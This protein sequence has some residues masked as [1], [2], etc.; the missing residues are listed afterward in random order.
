MRRVPALDLAAQHREIGPALERA[1]VRVLRSGTFILGPE[2]AAFESALA[3]ACGCRYAYGV[4]SGTDALELALRACGIGPGDEVLVPGFTF[5]ATALAVTTVGARPVLVDVEPWAFGIDPALAE[6]RVTRR[7]RAVIAVHLY[8]QPCDMA[9]IRRL[10]RR[11]RLRVIEDCA[12]AIGARYAGRPVGSVGD[13]GCF[14]F[15]PTKNLGAAGD[16]GAAVTNDR[17][18]ARRLALARN[19]GTV[20]K[21]RY[22]GFG[23]NSRLDELQ[24]ALLRV[25]LRRLGAWTRAR[26]LRARWYRA[27]I[28]RAGLQNIRLPQE[29]GGR[30]HVYH[31]FAVRVPRR[32][33]V[34]ER[35]RARGIQAM[36]YYAHPLNRASLYAGT[37][38]LPVAERL[39]GEVLALPMYPELSHA[40]VEYV[41]QELAAAVRAR[42]GAG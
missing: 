16:G 36:V 20:D 30:S 40:G 2:V 32:D 37:A 19:Y 9:G 31:V 11:H 38:R 22:T 33:A 6:T 5:M 41:V 26:R 18:L 25:K 28:R 12:Q 29:L 7:T 13:I 34:M 39:A 8:G 42:R 17:A 24:A 4:N 23:R 3:R 1:A 10:A 27:A 35:L 14:S 21:R 15:Y